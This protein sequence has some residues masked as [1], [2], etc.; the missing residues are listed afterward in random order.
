MASYRSRGV[1]ENTLPSSTYQYPSKWFALKNRARYWQDYGKPGQK[2]VIAS[3][4]E[5]Q[6]ILVAPI[7]AIAAKQVR[8]FSAS[9][10]RDNTKNFMPEVLSYEGTPSNHI[11]DEFDFPLIRSNN[12]PRY[13]EAQKNQNIIVSDYQKGTGKITY[14]PGVTSGTGNNFVRYLSI[15]ELL[16]MGDIQP[17]ASSPILIGGRWWTE[18]PYVYLL[19]KETTWEET[20]AY[21]EFSVDEVSATILRK[22]KAYPEPVT[23]AVAAANS[24]T[25]DALTAAAEAPQTLRSILMGCISIFKMY[26]EAKRGEVRFNDHVKKIRYQWSKDRA[27]YLRNKDI[28]GLK[29]AEKQFNKDVSDIISNIASLWLNWRLQIYPTSQDIEK[30]LDALRFGDHNVDFLR[31]REGT[32]E[33]IDVYDGELGVTFRS[34]IKRGVAPGAEYSAYFSANMSVTAWELVPLSFVIDR[35]MNIGDWLAA[36]LSTASKWKLTEGATLSWTIDDSTNISETA[37]LDVSF[38]KRRVFSPGDY[39]PLYFPESRS[40]N[41][42]LDHLALIWL[43]LK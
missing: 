43:R 23:A 12:Q 3:D 25:M 42:T 39:C 11:V 9:I 15:P 33:K 4:D 16:G 14:M 36:N 31:F 17:S 18:L 24:G 21:R 7:A 13:S 1:I 6:R 26:K 35:Y 10:G 38:Y 37:V 40:R 19:K 2:R 32:F 30:A 22:I 34:F 41:Q 27:E 28:A 5:V 20:S 8:A 29:T